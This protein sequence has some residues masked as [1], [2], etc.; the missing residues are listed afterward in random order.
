MT[1]KT[2]SEALNVTP[3]TV[4]TWFKSDNES[5]AS[6]Y[7][8]P[9]CRLF[10]I[11]PEELLEGTPASLPNGYTEVSEDEE[12]LLGLFRDLDW[13]GKQIVMS[14]AIEEHR[15]GRKVEPRDGK[16]ESVVG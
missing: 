1:Q 4:N 7:V 13:E 3:S 15:R 14:K 10:G 2:L 5:I 8:M 6:I 9:I 16:S 11:T 12:K